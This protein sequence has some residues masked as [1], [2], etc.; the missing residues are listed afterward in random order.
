MDL[1]PSEVREDTL[2]T[3]DY[4]SIAVEFD[5]GQDITCYWS[6]E[7]PVGPGESSGCG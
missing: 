5:N 1:L 3:H 4:M 7:L 2:T 6:A